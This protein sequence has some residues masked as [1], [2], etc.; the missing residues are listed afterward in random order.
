MTT[1]RQSG[2][3]S[4]VGMSS[5]PAGHTEADV[6]DWVNAAASPPPP[7]PSPPP[8]AP[9]AAPPVADLDDQWD[10]DDV[11]EWRDEADPAEW[12]RGSGRWGRR[13]LAAGGVLLLA[14]IAGAVGTVIWVNG[15]L[16]GSGGA[17]V[18]VSI[19][20]EAGHATL[21]K[22]LTKAGAVSDSWLFR[23]YLDYRGT[24]PAT[25][26]QYSFHHQEGYRAALRDLA[27][28]PK[29]VQVRLTI[30]EG[31]DL[32]QIAAEVGKLPG[33]S[34]QRFLALATA[35]QVRSRYEPASINSLEGLVFP[36]TYFIDDGETEQQIL[37]TLVDRF[38]QVADGVNLAT[39][40]NGLTPYQTIVLASLIEKEAK[41]PQDRGKIARVVLNRLA[42]H[43]R[44]QIDAT[45]EF[46]EG[47]H[48]TRL[49]DS[50]LRVN[51]PYNTYQIAGLP[52]GPI[53]SPGKASLAAALAPTPG[54]WL[55]YVLIN[56]D[57]EHGFATTS[58]EFDHLLAQARAK[59]LA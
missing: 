23:H 50:D 5:G 46:A 39:P 36:D 11:T 9:A 3:D 19:P 58:A 26:G 28:G 22:V 25:G 42:V 18:T 24:D 49:L 51:S 15:H 14:L 32:K 47:V 44:L 30:P 37:Q 8:A 12:S 45:V 34:A 13:L 7:P 17:P 29:I 41:V 1:P 59:G 21:A 4:V 6:P 27:V 16:N 40:S 33:L 31:Y 55:Y 54:T 35:G 48:K 56:P 20:P 38:D 10:D 53:A 52:P 2:D 43:M 57:G